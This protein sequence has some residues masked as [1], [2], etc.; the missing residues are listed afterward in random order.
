MQDAKTLRESAIRSTKINLILD[1]A[2]KL[3]SEKG[4]HD[5]RLEDIARAAGFSKASLYTYYVDKEAIF[6]NLAI[7]VYGELI[8]KLNANI[9]SKA[10]I[11]TNLERWLKTIFST[12]GEH[13]SIFL[14]ITNFMAV[15]ILNMMSLYEE[16][17][18]D[19]EKLQH[20]YTKIIKALEG[21]I[22]IGRKNG[23]INSPLD[24]I[25]ITRMFGSLI[26][27]KLLD[28]KLAG[29]IDNIDNAVN[30]ILTFSQSGLGIKKEKKK[31]R[32]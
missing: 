19:V 7:R 12:L 28:W 14:T 27:G 18:E 32:K 1:A 25:T 22:A 11:E 16:H 30:E 31:K 3:F 9:N 21:I 15:N 26:R 23:E 24:D 20:L 6:L 17:Q 4:F 29:K 8:E 2:L 13:A 5:T 10:S